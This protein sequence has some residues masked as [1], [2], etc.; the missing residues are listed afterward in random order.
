MNLLLKVNLCFVFLLCLFELN[1]QTNFRPG[2]VITNENDTLRGLIDYRGD[3]RNS[4]S[5]DFK[6]NEASVVK[7][8]KPFGIK[9]YRFT[10][11][12]FYVSKTVITNSM[13]V[14]LFLEFL[15][16]GKADLYYY[17]DG[18]NSHYFIEKSDKQIFELTNEEQHIFANGHEYIRD[19]KDYVGR[20]KNAFIDCPQIF[21]SIDETTLG[22]KSL[23][24]LTKKYHNYV[25]SDEKCIIY[26]KQ[27]KPIK[28]KFAPFAS[29]NSSSL[30][31][32]N[33]GLY[34]VIHFNSASFPTI[35]LQMNSTL[36]RANEK[37]SF[38]VSAEYGKS[39]FYG[40]GIA[41]YNY[42]PGTEQVYMHITSFTGK[43]GFKY[44]SPKGKIRPIVMVG[45]NVSFLSSNVKREEFHQLNSTTDTTNDDILPSTL[46]GYYVNFGIDYH[47]SSSLVTFFSIGYN[48][49]IG[50]KSGVSPLFVN[51]SNRSIPTNINT[52]SLIAGIY[53]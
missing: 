27:F 7:E 16:N 37:L 11:S 18:D 47:Y 41:P 48:S 53:F 39:N 1:G 2:Y 3:V 23:I 30:T 15:V 8:F 42:N 25:C 43:A 49:A 22:T 35:G 20:L 10:D 13:E 14:K 19:S 46:Y 5:C 17:F 12:K 38:Q 6:E 9:G 45:G 32:S 52:I 26:E 36:P 4:K 21:S 44:T 50:S 51:K 34:N 28:L 29:M 33:S 31:L 24:N 40:S